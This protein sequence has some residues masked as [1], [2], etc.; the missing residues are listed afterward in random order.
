M[1]IKIQ[2]IHRKP[3]KQSV[4]RGNFLA[5]Y[6]CIKQK[7]GFKLRMSTSAVRNKENKSKLNTK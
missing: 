4:L 5:L 6:T 3:L 2:Y 7:K 1:K